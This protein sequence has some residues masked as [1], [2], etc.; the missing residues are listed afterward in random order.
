[1]FKGSSF[2]E[3]GLYTTWLLVTGEMSIDKCRKASGWWILVIYE[4]TS[5]DNPE[6]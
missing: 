4:L 3:S 2:V 5:Y 6:Y 1:M